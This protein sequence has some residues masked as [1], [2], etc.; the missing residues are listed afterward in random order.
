MAIKQM[1]IMKEEDGVPSST[2]REIGLLKELKHENIVRLH[3]VMQ[4][5]RNFCLIFEFIEQDLKKFI[6]TVNR[7][8]GMDPLVM[9]VN[10]Q[11]S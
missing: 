3:G 9:K 4:I 8:L 10:Q 1:V 6:S 5:R 7:E 2:I 11:L